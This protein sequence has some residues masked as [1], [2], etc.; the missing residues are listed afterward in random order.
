[1]IPIIDIFAGPGGLGEGFSALAPHGRRVFRIALSVEME[2]NARETFKLRAFFRQ[3][4]LEE[5]PEEYYRCISGIL[6][7][8]E[9]YAN[10]ELAK[11]AA[12]AEREAMRAELGKDDPAIRAAAAAALR[13]YDVDF[14]CSPANRPPWILIGGPPCQAYSLVGRSRMRSSDPVKYK[15]DPRHTLYRHYLR[16]I[17]EYEP[18]VFVMENVKGILSSRLDGEMIFSKILADLQRPGEAHI[19]RLQ[20]HDSNRA[21]S[22]SRA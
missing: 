17:A 2:P 22:G 11:K 15:A 12:A 8:E 6:T 3:F 16:L 1:V 18:S 14:R 7:R 4:E 10:R 20:C 21:R 13:T 9:L 19:S 5:V